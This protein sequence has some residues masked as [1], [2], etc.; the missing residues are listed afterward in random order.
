[1][2]TNAS[3]HRHR[4]IH[5]PSPRASKN[6]T[7]KRKCCEYSAAYVRG[8]KAL[9]RTQFETGFAFLISRRSGDVGKEKACLDRRAFRRAACRNRERHLEGWYGLQHALWGSCV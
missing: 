7:N 4:S 3:M 2:A 6:S 1:M 8:E 9:E 5:S